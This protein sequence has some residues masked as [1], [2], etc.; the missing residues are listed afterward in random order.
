MDIEEIRSKL[1]CS[2]DEH[3]LPDEP[4]NLHPSVHSAILGAMPSYRSQE[5]AIFYIY[6]KMCRNFN[7]NENYYSRTLGDGEEFTSEFNRQELESIIATTPVICSRFGRIYKKLAE[8]LPDITAVVIARGENLDESTIGVITPNLIAR[9]DPNNSR[10]GHVS[11]LFRAKAGIN[12]LGIQRVEGVSILP[13]LN[14]VSG[15][16]WGSAPIKQADFFA[17]MEETIFANR[18]SNLKTLQDFTY[19]LRQRRIKGREAVQAVKRYKKKNSFGAATQIALAFERVGNNVMQGRVLFKFSDSGIANN[20]H[21]LNLSNM[22]TSQL[23]QTTVREM[24]KKGVLVYENPKYQLTL[25][26]HSPL[27]PETGYQRAIKLR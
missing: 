17:N 20:V 12:L 25:D 10:I 14:N 16:A 18:S 21:V 5:E 19:F 22:K 24:L 2:S 13:T 7:F 15:D 3:I 6:A 4:W 27:Q 11:D 1:K 23:R 8:G 26:E 9:L